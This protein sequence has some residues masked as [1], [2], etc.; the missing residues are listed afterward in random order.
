MNRLHEGMMANRFAGTLAT[1]VAGIA[2]GTM[3][4]GL[5]VA[6]QGAPGAGRGSFGAPAGLLGAREPADDKHQDES[7]PNRAADDHGRRV[8]LKGTPW[9]M[10]E[11]GRT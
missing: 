5:L 7:E 2:I 9:V 11:A 4:T 10:D 6:Q 8:C 3:A 1:L